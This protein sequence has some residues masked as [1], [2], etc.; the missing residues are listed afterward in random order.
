[1]DGEKCA[2]RVGHP[3]PPKFPL[4]IAW[5]NAFLPTCKVAYKARRPHDLLLFLSSSIFWNLS[6]ASWLKEGHHIEHLSSSPDST[7]DLELDQS[8]NRCSQIDTRS[9]FPPGTPS[10]HPGFLNMDFLGLFLGS[11]TVYFLLVVTLYAISKEA[12]ICGY[13]A[14]SLAAW[15]ALVICACYGVI[16]SIVL[17]L[18]GYGGLS[19]WTTAR[20]FKWTMK[21]F[22]GVEFVIQVGGR[23]WK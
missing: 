12:P 22:T 17:R 20:A 2:E 15:A 21:L 5:C 4:K 8:L 10:Q 7:T 13:Y 3:R 9:L 23:V 1:M 19:Q 6:L 16:S 14:R 18:S 11:L